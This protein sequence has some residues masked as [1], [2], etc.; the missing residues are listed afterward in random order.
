MMECKYCTKETSSWNPYSQPNNR[1][2][3]CC[4]RWTMKQGLWNLK[5]VSK[6]FLYMKLGININYVYGGVFN[7]LKH[8]IKNIKELEID[9]TLR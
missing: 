9:E 7:S 5:Q 3:K 4:W 8:R 1:Y 2:T 6:H